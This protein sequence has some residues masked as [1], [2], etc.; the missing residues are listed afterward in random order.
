ML[1]LVSRSVGL[2]TSAPPLLL[3]GSAVLLTVLAAA[4]DE[5]GAVVAALQ[6]SCEYHE[7]IILQS[8]KRVRKVTTLTNT[9]L[10]SGPVQLLVLLAAVMGGFAPTAA[11][12]LIYN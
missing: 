5:A 9:H 4:P 2:F 8:C 12:H 7:A 11:Q 3:V 6:V 10:M 1:V